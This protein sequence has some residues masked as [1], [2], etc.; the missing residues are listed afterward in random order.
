M[1]NHT[2]HR[3]IGLDKYLHYILSLPKL[4]FTALSHLF[5]KIHFNKTN[6]DCNQHYIGETTRPLGTQIKEHLLCPQPLSAVREHKLNTGHQC[7]MRDVNIVDLEENWHRREIKEAINIYREKPS[8]NRDIGQELP[9][10][11]Q[12]Y[13]ENKESFLGGKSN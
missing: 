7:A 11:Q 12:K 10:R 8:L 1:N 13:T 6:L 2:L 5:I 4:E 9:L 3:L